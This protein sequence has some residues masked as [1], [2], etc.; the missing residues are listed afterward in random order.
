MLGR[1]DY[2]VKVSGRVTG[3]EY[4]TISG[5]RFRVIG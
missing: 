2:Q 3:G 1:E 4:E 5:Y